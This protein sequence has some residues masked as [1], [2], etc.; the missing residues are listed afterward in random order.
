MEENVKKIFVTGHRNPDIDTLASSYAL[1]EL[2]RRQGVGNIQSVC[3]GIMPERAKYLF[4]RFHLPVPESRSD[5]YLRFSDIMETDT[6][7]VTEGTPLLEAVHLLNKSG[8]SRLPV[9]DRKGMFLGMLSPMNL[10][11][12]LLDVWIY[13]TVPQWHTPA[14]YPVILV[15]ITVPVFIVSVLAGK[16]LHELALRICRPAAKSQKGKLAP[17]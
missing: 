8:S 15:C 11:S 13:N 3:P 1:A 12:R 5:V 10:L 16:L 17:K 9:I 4:E 14:M 2:R 6:P 7:T